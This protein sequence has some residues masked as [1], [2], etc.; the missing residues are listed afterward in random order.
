MR[1]GRGRWLT[2][3]R[4]RVW[5][6]DEQRAS[7]REGEGVGDGCGRGARGGGR[8]G[9]KSGAG[10]T[11]DAAPEPQPS[12]AA[13][14]QVN[15]RRSQIHRR[16]RQIHHHCSR[17]CDRRIKNV[18][19]PEVANKLSRSQARHPPLQ[20]FHRHQRGT[21]QAKHFGSPPKVHRPSRRSSHLTRD[22]RRHLWTPR[23]Q[24]G[25][26]HV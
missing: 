17:I 15:H 20:G 25:R 3:A 18:T 6:K 23:Q 12:S 21:L 19:A 2:S 10:Y 5:S 22:P 9:R 13:L 14:A 1:T 24:I 4:R 16:R 26:A 8:H 7:G 11:E